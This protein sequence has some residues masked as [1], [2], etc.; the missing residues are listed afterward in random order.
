MGRFVVTGGAG[1]L[2]SHLTDSLLDDGHE[3]VAVDNL[4]TGQRQNLAH[5][6]QHHGFTF[7]EH[8]V[9]SLYSV[10][11]PVTAVYHLASPASPY[12][13]LDA[14]METLRVGSAGTYNMLELAR[15]K[16]AAFLLASTSEVYGDPETHPQ[17]ESYHGNVNPNSPRGV[18]DEGKRYAEAMTTAYHREYGVET[19]IARIFNTYGPRMRPDDGRVIPTFIRQALTGEPLTVHGD[20]T[21]TRSFCYVDDLIQGLRRLMQHGDPE[22]VNLGRPEEVTIQELAGIIH[23]VTDSR[24]PVEYIPR[25]GHDPDVRKPDIA[26]AR[27][28]LG[29]EPETSLEDGLGLTVSAWPP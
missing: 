17:P 3:V 20:G 12:D 10:E 9:V 1:F 13:Y 15:E 6:L 2:G 25:P 19:R 26:R 4:H 7:H 23:D 27:K 8:D 28:L 11:G 14:P 18:Y 21:Q 22:P 24:S 16:D 5:A 29:W